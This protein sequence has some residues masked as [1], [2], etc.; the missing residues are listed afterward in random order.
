M[1]DIIRKINMK[2]GVIK[3]KCRTF[4]NIQ[5]KI[6]RLIPHHQVFKILL[7]E[8]TVSQSEREL[9]RRNNFILANKIILI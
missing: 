7:E 3:G 5:R 9:M 8:M 2:I 1:N 4:K 6:E